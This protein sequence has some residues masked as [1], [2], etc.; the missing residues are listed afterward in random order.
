MWLSDYAQASLPASPTLEIGQ[1]AYRHRLHACWQFSPHVG[2]TEAFQFAPTLAESEGAAL[3]CLIVAEVVADPC[4]S[5][6]PPCWLAGA[7]GVAQE[8]RAGVRTRAGDSIAS[9]AAGCSQ[10]R[11]LQLVVSPRVLPAV[12]RIDVRAVQRAQLGSASRRPCCEQWRRLLQ[13]PALPPA[14]RARWHMPRAEVSSLACM[15]QWGP[16]RRATAASTR[17]HRCLRQCTP[18]ERCRLS[19]P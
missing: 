5:P 12:R 7:F 9:S 8:R 10:Q 3:A 2:R 15:Y 13:P 11:A 6:V 17:S 1:S 18:P 14:S 19:A 4:L 16:Q